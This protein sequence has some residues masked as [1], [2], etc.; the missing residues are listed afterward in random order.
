MTAKCLKGGFR[1]YVHQPCAKI[2][3]FMLIETESCLGLSSA[4]ASLLALSYISTIA[5]FV[6]E[7]SLL[8]EM[9]LCLQ[10]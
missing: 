7:S 10:L 2:S 6:S 9:P 8:Q 4:F 3:A 1:K 5:R